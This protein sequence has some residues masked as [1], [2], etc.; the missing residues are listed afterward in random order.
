M[1]HCA[2]KRVP[3]KTPC[4]WYTEENEIAKQRRRAL[5]K[6]WRKP[7]TRTP[8][9]R[10]RYRAQVN[11]CNRL[12]SKSMSEY[13]TQT[14]AQ[15]SGNSKQMRNSVNK[16]LLICLLFWQK[17][18]SFGPIFHQ[19]RLRSLTLN[20]RMLTTSILLQTRYS[21]WGEEIIIMIMSSSNGI[22]NLDPI[23]TTLLKSCIDSLIVPITNIVNYSLKEGVFPSAFKTAHVVLRLKKNMDTWKKRLLYWLCWICWQTIKIGENLSDGYTIKLGVRQGSVLGPILFTPYTTPLSW[24]IKRHSLVNHQLYAVDTQVYLRI[25]LQDATALME[26]LKV[27]LNYIKAWMTN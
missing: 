26:K 15:S 16:I 2:Q 7:A 20:L 25:S 12:L 5:E 13:Y 27:C 19:F 18:T 1:L 21:G 23:H 14:L 10:S 24:I 4:P 3:N 22:C 6:L 9:N 8:L 17:K 11:L